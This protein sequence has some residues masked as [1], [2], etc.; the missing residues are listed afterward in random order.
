MSEEKINLSMKEAAEQLGISAP[1]LYK[2]MR[3]RPDFPSMRL[4]RRRLVNRRLLAEWAE[5]E[6][7]GG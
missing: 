3:E 4:G 5:R 7:A 2:I 6:A 1:S